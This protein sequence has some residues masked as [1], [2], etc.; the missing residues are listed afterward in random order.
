MYHATT[1]AIPDDAKSELHDA[2]SPLGYM[3]P[4]IMATTL[5][6]FIVFGGVLGVTIF[7]ELFASDAPIHS[8]CAYYRPLTLWQKTQFFFGALGV[9]AV[10]G[11]GRGLWDWRRD[12]K[13]VDQDL[14]DDVCELVSFSITERH[15]RLADGDCS[16]LLVPAGEGHTRVLILNEDEPDP[17]WGAFDEAEELIDANWS[18]VKLHHS[19]F[20]LSFRSSGPKVKANAP[21]WLDDTD[22][23]D[24]LDQPLSDGDVVDVPFETLSDMA[25]KGR[26]DEPA[27]KPETVRA[28]LAD[29][30]V[31]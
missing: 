9:A 27:E 14:A 7:Q 31:T 1:T 29:Q 5:L 30:P 25:R 26:S 3:G 28:P 24:V 6:A 4:P 21:V 22:V 19:K 10:F 2:M 23:M 12:K 20:L 16:L 15:L 18:W 17:R 11:A 8:K 13:Q